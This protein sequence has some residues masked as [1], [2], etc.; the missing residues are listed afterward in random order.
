MELPIYFVL[1]TVYFM[2]ALHKGQILKR[3]HDIPAYFPVGGEAEPAGYL[4]GT[5]L[6]IK[7]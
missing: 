2:A 6:D 4:Q 1:H 5:L 7:G 3:P